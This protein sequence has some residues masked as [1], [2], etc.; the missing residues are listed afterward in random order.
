MSIQSVETHFAKM[1]GEARR[2][3]EV[4]RV[5]PPQD[6]WTGAEKSGKKDTWPTLAA[7]AHHG[8]AGDIVAA[9]EPHSEADPVALLVNILIG[10]GNMVG[11]GPYFSVESTRHFSRTNAILVAETSK[12]RKGT[13]WGSPRRLLALADPEWAETCIKSGLASGEGLIFE[14]RDPIKKQEPI[15]ENRRIVGYE[16]V[17]VDPGVT[18]KRR[19]VLEQEFASVLVL[20]ARE[21]N[22][23]SSVI[24]QCWDDDRLS[25]MTKNSPITATGAHIS[26]IG[27]ITRHELLKNL[28]ETERANGFANRYPFFVI[29]R[30]KA[31]PEGGAPPDTEMM[32]LGGRL[33]TKKEAAQQIGRMERDAAARELW[34]AVYPALSEGQPGLTGAILAR[35]EAHVLRFSMIYALLDGST[36]IRVPHLNA[37]LALWRY[38]EESVRIIFGDATGDAVS[39]RILSALKDGPM[40]EAEINNLFGRN[41]R[42]DKLKR[43]LDYL[44]KLGRIKSVKVD[45]GGR[46]ATQW[47]TK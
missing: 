12:G 31:L 25:P 40:M 37:A 1:Q 34:A 32:E 15:R 43:A 21:G 13:S 26:I 18:D 14:V 27:H 24:R 41:T 5:I 20:M 35:A 38:A 8:L 22:I 16:E 42:A 47:S 4:A 28:N 39:D 44:A 17:V 10:F 7:E 11:S 36:S 23:L 9:I 2:L 3:A 33:K 30:S 29:R 19:L 45:T 46:P 6:D